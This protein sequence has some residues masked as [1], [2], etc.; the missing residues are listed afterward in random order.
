[1]TQSMCQVSLVVLKV[2]LTMWETIF[3]ITIWSGTLHRMLVNEI[4]MYSSPS[5][6]Y[7]CLGTFEKKT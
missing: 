7:L 3:V 2:Y 4:G 1:M 6:L 5:V